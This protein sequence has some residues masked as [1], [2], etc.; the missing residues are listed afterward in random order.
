MDAIVAQQLGKRYR[1]RGMAAP[2]LFGQLTGIAKRKPPEYFWAMKDVSF[3]IEKGKT[4]GVIGPNGS[5]KS[6]LLGLTA[7]TICPTE[8]SIQTHGR[9]CSLLE[10]GA[11]FHPDL[12]GRENV[13][14]NASLLGDPA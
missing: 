14:L 5:G 1:M 13:F 7:G 10:L 3:S 2:T 6:S 11:G 4:I 9:V 12:T 8:G